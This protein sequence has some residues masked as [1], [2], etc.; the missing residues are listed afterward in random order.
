MS[1]IAWSAEQDALVAELMQAC[2]ISGLEVAPTRLWND[3]LSVSDGEIEACLG[4]WSTHGIR[5]VAMQALLFGRPELRLFDSD[6]VRAQM[7]DYLDGIMALASRLGVGQLVFGSPKNRSRGEL[8]LD[9]ALSIAT[10]FFRAAGRR[11]QRHGVVLCIEPN[12]P[13]Y[14]CDF[15]TTA[16]EALALVE[17]VGEPGFGLHLDAAALHM[18]GE[19]AA[20]AVARGI[21]VLR[22]VHAS[23]PRLGPLGEGG[24]NHGALA[25]ALRRNDYQ[26][27]VSVEMRHDPQRDFKK[28]MRRVM[29][30]LKRVYGD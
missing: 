11:A 2:G 10:E 6:A 16:A 12:P 25:A 30:Y 28:E 19:D 29:K 8:Q 5:V 17:R 7:L 22:H 4:F 24:V 3:P 18:V 21:R 15:I 27:Y 13:Q 1:N 23:E 14:D 9:A 26:G 20:T